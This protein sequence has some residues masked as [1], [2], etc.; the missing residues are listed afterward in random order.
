MDLNGAIRNRVKLS[1]QCRRSSSEQ[2]AAQRTTA[3]EIHRVVIGI[4]SVG[5]IREILFSLALSKSLWNEL[6][7]VRLAQ[8]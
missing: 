1:W 2:S 7:S 3:A 6:E 4:T 5:C 8:I